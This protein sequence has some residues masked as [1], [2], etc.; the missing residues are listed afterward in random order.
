MKCLIIDKT[1]QDTTRMFK[2]IGLDVIYRP[3]IKRPEITEIIG[4]FD[5]LIIRS[6]TPLDKE[7]IDLAKNLKFVGRA[8]AGV[9]NL[10]VNYLKAKGVEIMNAPEGNRNA[11]GEHTIG[12]LLSLLNNICKSDQ[13][14]RKMTWDREGNRGYE[15]AGKT[16]SLL[17]YGNMGQAFARKLASFNCKVL[18]YDKYKN[19]F[20]N[21]YAQQAEL[22]QIF[23]E[24][25]VFSIH[26]P[27]TEETNGM[28]DNEFLNSFKK[29]IY[30]LN[31][32]RGEVL[33]F[34]SC[35]YGLNQGVLKGI[36]LDVLEIE[37]LDQLN[38]EQKEAFE[39]LSAS[40]R[41]IMTPHIAGWSY[42]SYKKISEVLTEK[43]R[44]FLQERKK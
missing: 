40:N 33:P 36:G 27:L 25:D 39:Y 20:G 28:I 37:K 19:N 32:A 24:S 13:E 12:M 1:H 41:V 2:S 16:V 14:V 21:E 34:Q 38:K 7:L 23:E 10:D 35:V 15:L 44:L 6:K 17:G 8:G 9:D 26:V 43:I 3:D 18:A 42:E 22:D 30:L 29:P 4:E 31:T 11:L 5:G